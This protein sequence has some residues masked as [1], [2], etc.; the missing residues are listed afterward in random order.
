MVKET[1]VEKD[2]S[3]GKKLILHL[4]DSEF[5]VTSAFWLYTSESEA[6]FLYL[7]SNYVD[8]HNKKRAYEFIQKELLKFDPAIGLPLSSINPVGVNNT[9]GNLLKIVVSTGPHTLNEIRLKNVV[10]NGVM[11]ED[12]LIYRTS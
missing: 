8:N 3:D 2:I 7:A 1:L 6:W 12:A 9:Y 10:I 11:I 5:K 4:D